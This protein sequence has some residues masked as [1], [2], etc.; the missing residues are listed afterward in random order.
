MLIEEKLV[1][2]VD[3]LY[4]LHHN[5]QVVR[6]LQHYFLLQSEI[7]PKLTSTYNNVVSC[8]TKSTKSSKCQYF[9]TMV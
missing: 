2:K 3:M 6:H 8:L 1:R 5:Q 9:Q 7:N 4:N